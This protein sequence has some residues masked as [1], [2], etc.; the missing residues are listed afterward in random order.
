MYVPGRTQYIYKVIVVFIIKQ[1]K[2][3]NRQ[4]YIIDNYT[5]Y[6]VQVIVYCIKQIFVSIMKNKYL[7]PSSD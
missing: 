5:Y 4:C 1:M 7:N 2:S 6:I 3:I